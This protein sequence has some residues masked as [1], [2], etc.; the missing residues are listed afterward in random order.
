MRF[1]EL[2]LPQYLRR[3]LEDDRI[4]SLYPP[5]EAAVEKGVLDGERLVVATPTASGKTLIAIM[6]AAKHLQQGGRVLYLTPLRA[7]AAE[8]LSE[9]KKYLRGGATNGRT[10]AITVT[11]GDYDSSDPWLSRYDVVVATNE[12]ADSLL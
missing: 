3:N 10:V 7:L 8:K 12:K 9:F 1:S 4:D 5:Q 11:S 2:P 6:A